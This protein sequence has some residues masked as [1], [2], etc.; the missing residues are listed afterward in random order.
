VIRHEADTSE[1]PR[2]PKGGVEGA[3]ERGEERGGEEGRSGRRGWTDGRYVRQGRRCAT[4]Y[5]ARKGQNTTQEGVE[6]Y[7]AI[8]LDQQPCVAA[9][10]ERQEAIHWQEKSGKWE[11]GSQGGDYQSGRARK[12]VR[13]LS[14]SR[15]AEAWADT[16]EVET[17][18]RRSLEIFAI[19]PIQF[20]QRRCEIRYLPFV[21]PLV[22]CL[23]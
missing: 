16:N 8:C 14:Q 2:D 21:L 9:T 5:K 17:V 13:G 22:P 18:K 3:L 11:V 19:H 4:Q 6:G 15:A 1:D 7:F 10:S 12:A 20:K 23:C